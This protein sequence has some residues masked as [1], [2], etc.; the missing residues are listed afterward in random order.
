MT[1]PQNTQWIWRPEEHPWTANSHVARL[2]RA[3]GFTRF[4]DLRKKAAADTEWFW[5]AAVR[6]MDLSWFKPYSKVRDASAGFPWTKWFIDGSINITYNCID[7]HCE[8]HHGDDI[9]LIYEADSGDPRDARTMNYRQLH[10]SVNRCASAMKAMGIQKGDAVGL[11]APMRIETVVAF[12]AAMKIGALIVPV[13]CG[14]GEHALVERLASCGAKLLFAA[15]TLMRRGKPVGTAKVANAA[16]AAVPSI[17]RVV[18]IDTPQWDE[19]L[20]GRENMLPCEQTAAEDP[21]MLIYTSGTTGKPKGTVHTHI[22]CLAQMGKE[23]RYA[24]DVHLGEPFFWVTDIGWMMGPWTLIGALLYRA[25]VVLFDGAPNHPDADRI[26]QI[27]E[28]HK[29]VTLGISP[30]LIR[31]LM[32]ETNGKGPQAYDLSRLRVLGST[33]E[34]WDE[35]SYM[36]FFENVGGKRCPII[37]ISGGTEIVGCHLMPHPVEPLKACTLG[38]GA[39]G[40]DVDVFNEQGKPVRNSVGYLV[41]KKPAPSMT[42]SFLGD[43]ERYLETYFSKFPNIWNHGDW[44]SIDNDGLWY[45]HGRADDTIKVA[46]KRVGPAEVESI[47]IANPAVSEAATIGVPDDLKG[48]TLVCFVVLKPGALA[49]GDALVQHVARELGKPLAPKAVHAVEALPKTRSGKIVRAAI[50]RAYLGEP[51]GDLTSIEN[52]AA[53]ESIRVL[54][55]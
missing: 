44:A 42:K 46:G 19:F 27:L 47:L 11:Y 39:L 32:R 1:V 53:L 21:C 45:L 54:A 50:R 10:K 35:S 2:M 55:K 28:K 18:F 22:G 38:G 7:R 29:V 20:T 36:W 26:W 23:L 12:F 40:M 41:C 15:D 24:F 48:Q 14:F 25:P 9:A 30:T 13:F 4:A 52:P 5:D 16:A 31:L 6:D 34:P 33:G 17:R 3:H 37:N 8:H 43:D 49:N 51:V